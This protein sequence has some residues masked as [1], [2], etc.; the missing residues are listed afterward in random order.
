MPATPTSASSIVWTPNKDYIENARLT[1]F[2]RAY[3]IGSFD[4]LMARSTSDVAW[5]TEAVLKFLDIQFYEP[6]SKVVDLSNG[7]MWPQWCVGGRMNIVHNCLDKYIGTTTE[8][9]PA[10]VWEGENGQALTLT[11]G[12]LYARVNQAASALRSLGLG[13]GDAVGI[14]MPMVPE[15]VV[16]L[17]AIAKI[18]GIILPLFSGYGVDA[19]VSR[20]ADADAKALFTAD[21]FPRRGKP[22][23]MKSIADKAAG[24][25]PNLKHLI[26]LKH[27]NIEVPIL[28]GRDHWWHEFLDT[29][30][31]EADTER[32][33][34]EDPLMIIYTS[35]TTGRPKGAV[36]THCGFPVKAA[37]DMAFGT[38][39]RP[40][41]LIYWMTDLGWMM[42]PWLVFGALLLGATFFLYDGAHDFPGPNRL[43]A[44]VEK[45]K[46]TTLGVS[47]T[48]IRAL[49][50]FGEKPVKAHDLSALR[51]FASTGEPWNP[52]PWHWLFEVVGESKRPI[53]NYSGG[54]EISGGILMGNPILPL[55]AT[56]FA[57]PCPGMA[58]DVFNEAGESVTGEV[59]ELVIKAPWIGMT[60]GFWK[61]PARYEETYW[62]RWPNVWVHGDWAA[63]D[64]DGLWYILGRS[65][66]TIKVAGKRLGP[67]EVESVLVA[68][69]QVVEAAAIAVPDELKGNQVVC[70]CVLQSGAA[71]TEELRK[72]LRASLVAALG[73]PLA[74]K[75]LLFVSDLPKTRNAKVMRRMVRAAYLGEPAGDTSSLVNPEAVEEI[76]RAQ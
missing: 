76:R 38:D 39:V 19:V 55:K 9:Q 22:V 30:S 73:K 64:G 17:L 3:G 14:F 24:Q 69:P 50:P 75:A 53:I 41:H 72:E 4:D 58:A 12:E 15:I 74:P 21:G 6:Y 49:I 10:L 65:D 34:A 44:L 7:I 54:T 32:I 16:A 66:D 70:F 48:L 67:A 8:N 47:P 61:D 36:H 29:Q 42:G 68:H 25:L 57:G 60:R 11:Y 31:P 20:L 71:A 35:G 5:F 40:G 43:W 23:E 28:L 51:Y 1:K 27:A 33:A 46:I 56:A 45:H 37:Q 63:K 62:S 18:G 13:K 52:D 26:V 2:M 59:G